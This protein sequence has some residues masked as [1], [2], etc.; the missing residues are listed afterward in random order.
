MV[1][2]EVGGVQITMGVVVVVLEI[3]LYLSDLPEAG[4]D[5]GRERDK[6]QG[7]D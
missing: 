6:K 4:S 1:I 2:G 5:P 7:G 3:N